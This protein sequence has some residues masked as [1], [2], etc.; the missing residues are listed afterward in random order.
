MEDT[1]LRGK[2]GG[3]TAVCVCLPDSGLLPTVNSWGKNA[4]NSKL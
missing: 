1:R 2:E 3:G 4:G